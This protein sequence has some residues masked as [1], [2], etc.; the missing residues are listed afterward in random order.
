MI[1]NICGNFND[2]LAINYHEKSQNQKQ[3]IEIT[4]S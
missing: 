1:D 4:T 3:I 2:Y